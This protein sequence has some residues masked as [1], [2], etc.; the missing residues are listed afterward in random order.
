MTHAPVPSA[1]PRK[2]IQ[3]QHQAS[4]PPYFNTPRQ[5][6]ESLERLEQL[7]DA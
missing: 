2:Q 1:R 4:M 6:T 3:Q 7:Y 5:I